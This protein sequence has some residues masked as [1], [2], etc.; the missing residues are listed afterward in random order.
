MTVAREAR[1]LT[2]QLVAIDSVN[3]TLVPGGAGEGEIA[4]FVA[5]WLERAGLDVVLEEVATGRPNVIATAEGSGG[6]RSLMLNAHLDTVSLGGS[7]GALE[8]RVEGDR[9]YGRGS[10]DMKGSL[11]AIML[12][13]AELA[14]R[15]LAGDLIVT[16]VCDEEAGSVGTEA[17]VGSATADAAVVTEPTE[18]RV[19]VAHRG[20][21]ALEV[22][23]AGRAA[24]GS[25]YDLGI[26]A[27]VRM[28][29]ILTA[30]GNVDE[31][32][33][34]REPHPLLGR[35]SVH[36]S[37]IEGGQELSSYPARCVLTLERRTLPGET[38]EL[39]EK[40]VRDAA[41]A[42]AEIRRL[43]ARE[44]LE[45]REDEPI[46]QV[47]RESAERILGSAPEVIGVPFWTDAALLSA[48][49]IPTVIFGPAGEGAHAE[50][51]WVDLPSVER[52]FEVL[53]ATAQAFCGP[54]P[55][56]PT[57]PV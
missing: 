14:R 29:L 36:A 33:G 47:V 8:A 45:T 55:R 35:P 5:R 40:E 49:G 23:T 11:A 51:E 19:A 39:V 4:A 57:G 50:T 28:G 12:V 15:P 1:E 2:A 46:V 3:P 42:D 9:L 13:A 56:A 41:G 17:V 34:R 27:I 16:A 44:P 24:H 30:L 7:D 26:D 18:L 38:P 10:Y 48:A 25:R 54:Q 20:F 32:L 31:L 43:F 52:C 21:V 6:G 37:L 53:L 22:E